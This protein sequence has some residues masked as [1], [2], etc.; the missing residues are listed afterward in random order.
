MGRALHIDWNNLICAPR[1]E[2]VPQ[3]TATSISSNLDRGVCGKIKFKFNLQLLD[4][5]AEYQ[6]GKHVNKLAYGMT[7]ETVIYIWHSDTNNCAYSYRVSECYLYYHLFL[8]I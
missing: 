4:G 2:I 3:P 7:N 5:D 8:I 1:V 6:L